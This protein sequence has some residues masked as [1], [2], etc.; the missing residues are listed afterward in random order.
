[1]SSM[2]KSDD[3]LNLLKDIAVFEYVSGEQS[4]SARANFEK[5]LIENKD[6]EVDVYIEEQLRDLVKETQEPSPVAQD[7]IQSLFD[8]ID[9]ETE[10]QTEVTPSTV[11][12]PNFSPSRSAIGM[13][14]AMAACLLLAVFVSINMNNDLLEPKFQTLSSPTSDVVD[15]DVLA[16]E[17]RLIK[18]ELASSLSNNAIDSLMNRYALE[19][20]SLSVDG[21]IITAKSVNAVDV[22]MLT[23]L[24]S[25][26]L[27][28][29]VELIKFK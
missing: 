5:E 19:R 25:D 16:N 15:L 24:K 13:G 29:D 3:K 26:K 21:R 12:R 11:V 22:K 18:F 9:G 20:L 8:R 2:S 23:T 27:I 14:F 4:P 28:N 10:K 1:V 6:L 17:G 7:N